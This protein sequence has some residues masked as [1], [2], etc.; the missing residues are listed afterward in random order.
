MALVNKVALVTGASGGIGFAISKEF[1]E[2]QGATVL[3][4]SR[5]IQHAI[6]ASQKIKGNTQAIE[7][8]VTNVRNVN[9][10]VKGAVLDYGG[11]DILVNSAGHRFENGIWYKKYHQMTD[12][13]L[14]A[15]LE[16]DLKGTVHMTRAFLPS[17]IKKT[18]CSR[19][20]SCVIINIAS[21]PALSGHNEGAPYAIVKAGVIAVTKHIALEYGN[22]RIRAYTLALGNIATAATYYSMS[23]RGRRKA[24]TEP[25]MKRWGSPEEVARVAACLG[26]ESFS[27]ATGNT[28]IV[29]G[30]KIFV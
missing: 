15:I 28:I 10:V 23:K 22:K 8:D 11:I 18:N 7:L 1:A 4:C 16:V 3:V 24:T 29:D 19:G 27:Y 20:N 13:A 12:S 21:T 9:S 17:M 30:G 2:N 26:S 6:R 14:N 25:A 5:N